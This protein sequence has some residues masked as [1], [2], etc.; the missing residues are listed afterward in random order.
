MSWGTPYT[1]RSAHIDPRDKFAELQWFLGHSVL[2]VG[3]GTSQFS[4]LV[5][6][7]LILRAESNMYLSLCWHYLTQQISQSVINNPLPLMPVTWG[8]DH[9]GG[10]R[11]MR[12]NMDWGWRARVRWRCL[13]SILCHEWDG[14][15]TVTKSG[16]WLTVHHNSVWIRN[17]LDVTFVLSFISP[18]QVAQHVSGSHVPI[19]R[20]W[21]L[22]SVIT[23]CWYCAVAAGRLSELIS[24]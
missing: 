5:L 3:A 20:S 19:L 8:K 6:N 15:C 17:Q 12:Q 16:V 18:L 11:K 9:F 24:R 2:F 13:T 7:R 4:V 23:T 22:C 1:T 21:R 10:S 14:R